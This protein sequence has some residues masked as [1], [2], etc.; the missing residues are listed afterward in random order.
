MGNRKRIKS[1]VSV[2]DVECADD[3]ALISDSYEILSIFHSK[4]N[5]MRHT[6]NYKKTKLLAVLPEDVAHRP[7]PI[8]L[9]PEL[10][11]TDVVPSFQY[12]LEVLSPTT[13]VEISA[14]IIDYQSI[15]V[16]RVTQPRSLAP[17]RERS[18]LDSAKLSFS[19]CILSFLW[20]GQ[21]T[22]VTLEPRVRRLQRFV[23]RD[24]SPPSRGVHGPVPSV[25]GNHPNRWACL[26]A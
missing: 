10:D 25:T 3:M 18:N 26:F 7:A 1:D 6:I 9:R 14:R 19:V 2:A 17:A 23:M 5:H 15:S 22:A 20:Y 4:Y 24:T 11:H 12:T 16:I 8:V 21:E 13:E